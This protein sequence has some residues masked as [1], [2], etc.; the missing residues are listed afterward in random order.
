MPS[1][2]S[3][4]DL[5]TKADLLDKSTQN[6][7]GGVSEQHETHPLQNNLCNIASKPSLKVSSTV[8][9]GN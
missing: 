4:A 9:G 6:D 1:S 8:S 5:P 2:S 3:L 7:D